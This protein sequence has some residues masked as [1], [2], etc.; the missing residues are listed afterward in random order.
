MRNLPAGTVTFLFTDIEG[1]TKLWEAQP[2]AMQAALVRHDALLRDAIETHNGH[3]FKTIGDAFCA[4]FPTATE[5]ITAALAAQLT[6]T[7]EPWPEQI[8]LKVRMA[9]HTGAVESRNDDYFGQPLNRVARLLATGHGGQ[10]LLTLATQ[11]LVR[12]ALPSQTQFRDLGA[13]QLKDLAR[14]EQI[15]QMQHPALAD[16]FPALKSLSTH[17]NNLPQQV[18]SFI[19]REEELEIV[20][21]LLAKN[22]LLT[23]TG[24]GGSGKSRLSLQVAADLLERFPEGAFLVELAPLTDPNF[25]AQTVASVL[26]VKEEPGKP[27][28]TTLTEQLKTKHLLLLLDNCEHVLDACAR[29]A[30]ALMRGCP[31]VQILATSR[32]GLGITGEATYRVPSLSLPDPKQSQTPESLSHF[33]AVRLFID[34]ALQTQPS[35]RVTNENA[36]ALASVC[37]HLDGIPLAIGLAAARARSLSV[38]EINSKLDQRFRLLT[39]GSR[40]ALPRQQTLRALIDWSYDLLSETEKKVLERLAVFAGGWTL[41]A[42]EAV[43]A[44]D[45]VEDW[46][47]LDHLTSLTDKNLV[48]AE[49]KHGHT[50]YQ[51]LETVRQY[52]RDRLQE[53]GGGEVWCERHLAYFVDLAEQAEPQMSRQEQSI[54]YTR[55]E[56]EHDNFRAALTWACKDGSDPESGLQLVGCLWRFWYNRADSEGRVWCQLALE[57]EGKRIRRHAEVLRRHAEVLNG[58]GTLAYG[59]GDYTAAHS[60]YEESLTL[61]RDQGNRWGIATSLS[62]LGTLSRDQG[63]YTAA[64]ALFEESLALHRELGKDWGAASALH[65]LGNVARLQEDYPLAHSLLGES[66][67]LW[68][69]MG[70]QGNSALALGSLGLLAIEQCDSTAARALYE[71]SLTLTYE[72]GNRRFLADLLEGL[73][74]IALAESAPGRTAR[75]KGAAALLRE[76]LGVGIAPPD[77][78]WFDQWTDEARAALGADAFALAWAEGRTLTLEQVIALALERQN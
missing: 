76:Q 7:S 54:W 16:T 34:R 44:S 40:T 58:A 75:L 23:L 25:V 59:Q 13:H 11:E 78:R 43:C 2:E 45:D 70:A 72:L 39:G 33:E 53:R 24:A 10:T 69:E 32:E 15:Y 26:Q 1:S 21:K 55:L 49:Q 48:I 14:A 47:V 46:E 28:L 18:T 77:Q 35:F 30:D 61:H 36:P 9:L 56:T 51:L 63:N 8:P 74:G 3:V 73:G 60:L 50:R 65:N 27:I 29:L 62:N 17:P 31:S 41:E 67:A 5:A 4:A 6:L 64:R 66:L 37:F 20:E 42:A 22:K 12:D 19:G 68:Q 52:A 71:K 38:E 57:I